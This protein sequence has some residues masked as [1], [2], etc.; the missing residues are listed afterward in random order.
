MSNKK[1]IRNSMTIQTLLSF[2]VTLEILTVAEMEHALKTSQLPHDI[3]KR[4]DLA[5]KA[6]M[7]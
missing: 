1:H 5:N 6:S 4:L 2:F 3:L 7:N